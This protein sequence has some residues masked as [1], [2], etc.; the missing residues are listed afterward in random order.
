[1]NKLYFLGA[2]L[3]VTAT[4]FAQAPSGINYQA[5]VRDSGGALLV[6]QTVG[7]QISIL[8]GSSEGTAVYSETQN[9]STNSNGLLSLEIGA[10][11]SNGNLSSID[12]SSGS[13]FIKTETDPTGG[14]NYSISGTSRLT[15]VPYAMQSKNA[16]NGI[17]SDQ[18]AAITAN[19]SKEGI[20]T[21]QKDAITTNTAKKGITTAQADIIDNTSGANT[22][23]NA[24]NTQYGGLD[25]SKANLTGA[26]FTGAISST[27][28]SNSNTGDETDATIKTKLSITTL[29]GS[30]T[31][32]NAT[33][34]QYSDQE[35]LITS[36]QAQIA[37]LISDNTLVS[38]R[39]AIGTQMWM[40]KNLDVATYRD[41]TAIPE[42]ADA[43][44]WAALKTGAWCYYVGTDGTTYGKLYNW[45][46][47]MGITVAEDATPTAAQITARKQLA[48]SG[49][50]VPSDG[51]WSTLTTFLDQEAPTG[52]VGG[53]MKETGTAHWQAPNSGANNSSGFT[54][55]PGGFRANDG[56]FFN[57][58]SNGYWWSSPEYTTTHAWSRDLK[59]NDG[60]VGKNNYVMT[61][62]F[63]VRCLRD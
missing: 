31:G 44:A 40:N 23:D 52:N 43:G 35:A 50:H 55:L 47:V 60:N 30:N 53:K 32:D 34:T 7:M 56:T 36:L 2:L 28:L 1:M 26:I 16:D 38:R 59:H 27:N 54:G 12:W 49:L 41:G 39:I 3:L 5:I 46:A 11:T 10:G 22:G 62:G 21:A 63:S 18:K 15:S 45:Y 14:S 29:S 6:S 57:I 13:Y 17:T 33:N 20:T 4:S 42:V 51:E 48:P 24:T 19:T 58:G 8:E 25:G 37:E 61:G 9:I